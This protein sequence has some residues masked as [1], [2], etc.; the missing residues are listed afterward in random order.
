MAKDKRKCKIC[1]RSKCTTCIRV[2]NLVEKIDELTSTI[3]RN[4]RSQEKCI[5]D[6]KI[7]Y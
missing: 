3:E 4:N 6:N 7:F 1:N 5:Y 2:E